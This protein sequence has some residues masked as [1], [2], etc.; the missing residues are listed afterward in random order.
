[1][2]KDYW[3]TPRDSRDDLG[4]NGCVGGSA[5]DPGDDP[6]LPDAGG[7]VTAGLQVL[8]EFKEGQ[9]RQVRDVGDDKQVISEF[10]HSVQPG[11]GNENP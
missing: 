6:K 1:M 4:A 9:G 5:D 11:D 7:R 8:Y 3:D 10:A 2:S